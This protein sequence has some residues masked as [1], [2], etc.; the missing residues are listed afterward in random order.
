VLHWTADDPAATNLHFLAMETAAD[1]AEG[2]AL[3]HRSG[4]ANENI[5][6]AGTDGSIAWTEL[7][8]IP[9]RAGYDGRLP[10]SWAYGDRR[11]D[12]WLKPADTPVVLN[13]ADGILWTAN[14]RPVGGEAYGRLGDG[15]YDEGPRARQLRDDLR[16][17][18]RSGKQAVPADLFAIQLDDRALFLERWHRFFL[19]TLDDEAVAQKPARAEIRDAL[20]HWT[21]RAGIEAVAY[22]LVRA[23]RGHVAQ[24]AFAPFSAGARENYARFSY[25]SFLYED[26]LW[27]LVHDQPARLLNPDHPT[28]RSLLLAAADD[29][30]ADVEQTGLSAAHFTWGARNTLA[31]QHPFGRFLPGPVA[32]LLDM[33]AQPLPGDS[34]MPRVQGPTHGQSERLV[35]SPGHED[36][37]IF[38]MPGGQSGHPLSPYDRAG[39]AAWAGGEARPLLPGPAQ[40][41]LVLQP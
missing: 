7:G 20:Q 34:D 17:L 26:A 15:G 1:V 37:G 30:L 4:F 29:V 31:M 8:L 3:A 14:N 6:I 18:V 9:V 35:V 24:R 38:T 40:H 19:A 5:I 2:V 36:Q 13:P 16:E 33:P 25:R 23:F 11:W 22:R 27:T 32:R 41:T 10:V 12:G 28:W 21:G 39:H